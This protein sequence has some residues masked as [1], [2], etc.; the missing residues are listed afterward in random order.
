MVTKSVPAWV[1]YRQPNITTSPCVCEISILG[2]I[3][4]FEISGCRGAMEYEEVGRVQEAAVSDNA[5]KPLRKWQLSRGRKKWRREPH[6]SVRQE[7]STQRKRMWANACLG[8]AGQRD[9][10][11]GSY[12]MES[13]EEG[14]K[15]LWALKMQKGLW[16]HFTYDRKP[17]KCFNVSAAMRRIDLRKA[18]EEGRPVGKRFHAPRW[19]A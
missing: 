9:S 16:I 8:R 2:W 7:H 10:G 13:P 5:R 12:W 17:G 19:E 6:K 11:E 1:S 14:G 15:S 3:C 18:I 4:G